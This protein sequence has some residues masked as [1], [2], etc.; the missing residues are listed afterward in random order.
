MLPG[1][2]EALREV[3]ASLP[4][5]RVETRA[6]YSDRN[7]MLAIVYNVVAVPLAFAGLVTPLI[8]AVAMSGSSLLVVGNALRLKGAIR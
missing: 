2:R 8:A 5:L 4:I 3:D 1:L 7:F 6:Q